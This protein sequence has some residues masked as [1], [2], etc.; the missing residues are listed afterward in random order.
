MCGSQRDQI[1]RF[2]EVLGKK[3]AY[4]SSAKKIG[5]FWAISKRTTLCKHYFFIYLCK[6][7]NHFGNIF[8]PISGHTGGSRDAS[9]R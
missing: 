3:F 4:K 9:R 2:L 5:G 1:G 7:G 6:F 8:I